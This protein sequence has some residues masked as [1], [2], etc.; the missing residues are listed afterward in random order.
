MSH[1]PEKDNGGALKGE[2]EA[3]KAL[4][5]EL[6]ESVPAGVMVLSLEGALLQLN[7][8]ATAMFDIK[9]TSCIGRHY[10]EIV[11]RDI[12]E[13]LREALA[14]AAK[15]GCVVNMPMHHRVDKA[16]EINLGL[17]ATLFDAGGEQRVILVCHDRTAVIELERL[18][19]VDAQK[20]ESI[21]RAAHELKNPLSA[22]KAYCD[23]LKEMYEPHD[24]ASGFVEGIAREADHM[25]RLLAELL[26][27]SSIESGQLKLDLDEIDLVDVVRNTLYSIDMTN[28]KH[29]LIMRAQENMPPVVAD[30][31]MLREVATNLVL[32]AIQY[33]PDGGDVVVEIHTEGRNVRMDVIDQ[34]I[35]IPKEHLANIFE[36]FYRVYTPGRGDI[37]GSGL[38]LA[39]VKGIVEAHRGSV[40]VESAPG[41]GSRF[42]VLLPVARAFDLVREQAART[43][44]PFA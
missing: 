27:V 22:V 33:S 1:T 31:M 2:L 13:A 40:N 16:I 39:I 43:Q 34:G 26:N 24:P 36:K 25:L 44:Q 7:R 11:P 9:S 10:S 3:H 6:V 19:T 12:A 30:P 5:R 20:T 28:K 41:K 17:N 14:E 35:G 32:N 4:W 42:S 38:G 18:R 15:N 21:C 29:R 23:V 37:P 8:N